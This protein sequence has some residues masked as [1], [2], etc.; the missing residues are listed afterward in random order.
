MTQTLEKI[1]AELLSQEPSLEQRDLTQKIHVAGMLAFVEASR[2]VVNRTTMPTPLYRLSYDATAH[3]VEFDLLEGKARVPKSGALDINMLDMLTSALLRERMPILFEGKTGVGKTFT[4][5]QFFKTIL[6]SDNYRGL[7]L[8]RSMT[9]VL[10][11]YIEGKVEGGVVK[12]SLKRDELDKIAA[13][14]IDEVNRGDSNQV[15][16]LQDGNVR[17]GTGE[18]GEFGIPIPVYQDGI[19]TTNRDNKR[20]FFVVSAQNP[21]A[22]KDAKY[23][24]TRGTDAAQGNRNLMIETPNQASDIG[25]GVLLLDTGNGQ[26]DQFV[27]S[28]KRAFARNLGLSSQA[29]V[30]GLNEDWMSTY[31]FVT[32]PRRTACPSIQSSIEFMDALL[33]M[34][35][36]DLEASFNHEKQ[37]IQYWNA[38]LQ[39]HKVDFGYTS[40]LTT[41]TASIVKIEDIV[42]T[43]KED[44]ITRDILKVKKLSDAISLTRRIKGAFAHD[45][46]VQGYMSSPNFVTI[47]DVA[48]GFAIMLYDKQDIHEEDPVVLIDTVLREYIGIVEEFGQKRGYNHRFNPTNPGQS[49]Y[50]L[51]L[52]KAF[53]A[54]VK[55]PGLVGVVA[56]A[57][58]GTKTK[59]ENIIHDLGVSVA[60]LKRLEGGN[61]YRKPI[62][63]RMIA[64]LTTLAGFT[65]QYSGELEPLLSK[66]DDQ[67]RA[68]EIF[69][70]FYQEKRGEVSTPDIY[71]HRL[72]RVLGA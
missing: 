57:V 12:I 18:A 29:A 71:L 58:T 9:N 41:S 32:D 4:V 55:K 11:P 60:V 8:N 20:A 25:A 19:W 14:F 49:I 59:T 48:S 21:P 27:V 40:I 2:E 33:V 26:H 67:V 64:D 17:L 68:R 43:F 63:G 30:A 52:A 16:Q 66:C 37:T 42:R 70:E 6:P 15:L 62:L 38:A 13:L 72:T 5:E 36:P 44:I 10:Q 22:T 53:N 46:P 28:Y 23:S 56:S 39:S 50:G 3:N 34:V 31:A 69:T 47:Q 45:D 65:D 1:T 51:T 35:A 61:E 54:A 7:R 24:G